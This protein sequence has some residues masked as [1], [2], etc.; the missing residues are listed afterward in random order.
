MMRLIVLLVFTVFFSEALFAKVIS[1]PKSGKVI[2]EDGSIHLGWFDR[3]FSSISPSMKKRAWHCMLLT[4]TEVMVGI[5]VVKTSYLSK[6][7]IYV[8]DVKS[9]E[10][11]S[12]KQMI[13][14]LNAATIAP[15][16]IHGESYFSSKKHKVSIKN[17][18]HAQIIEVQ[19]F[20]HGHE[21]TG[22][23]SIFEEGEPMVSVYEVAPGKFV[24]T[25]QNIMYSAEGKIKVDGKEYLFKRDN[26]FAFMDYTVG[27]HPYRSGWQAA[28]ARGKSSDGDD[29]GINLTAPLFSR[30]KDWPSV[31]WVNGKI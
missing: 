17:S 12:F 25:H 19:S 8:T 24:Y 2:E 30:S 10:S 18:E 31:Y 6:S 4:N 1:T 11:T 20:D 3:P 13:P 26:S 22:A 14:L 28:I 27:Q 5:F 9:G 7:F 21:I 23:F 29:I 16:S 15:S